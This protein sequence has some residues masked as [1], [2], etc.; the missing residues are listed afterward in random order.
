VLDKC[1][2]CFW[3]DVCSAEV[4]SYEKMLSSKISVVW[5]VNEKHDCSGV[6]Y[7][8]IVGSREFFFKNENGEIFLYLSLGCCQNRYKNRVSKS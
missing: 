8:L 2:G 5:L 7:G 3:L 1:S 6:G 4:L